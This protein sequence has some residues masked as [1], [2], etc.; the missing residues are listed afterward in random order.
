MF[1]ISP[2]TICPGTW[3]LLQLAFHRGEPCMC[4]SQ[5]LRCRN[6]YPGIGP[7]QHSG[8]SKPRGQPMFGSRH[9]GPR[10]MTSGHDWQT[11][12]YQSSSLILG[13]M[14]AKRIFGEA[15]L[16]FG[17]DRGLMTCDLDGIGSIF[18]R[19]L[20]H[21]REF[22]HLSWGWKHVRYT[23]GKNHWKGIPLNLLDM[24]WEKSLLGKLF[25]NLLTHE[26]KS[27]QS[28][29]KLRVVTHV[30][31]CNQCNWKTAH[32]AVASATALKSTSPTPYKIFVVTMK[33]STIPMD[34]KGY[35]FGQLSICQAM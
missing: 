12:N 26:K 22:W 28:N 31:F 35:R 11:S 32:Q 33:F 24:M 20:K 5:I 10:Y 23:K 8:G 30:P 17:G 29:P 34:C 14:L 27:S 16:V 18:W 25:W 13:C 1:L 4:S 2:K 19:C 15:P 6:P 7:W 21:S 9:S 3:S